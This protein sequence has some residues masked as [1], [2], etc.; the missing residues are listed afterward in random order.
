MNIEIYL[1]KVKD[2]FTYELLKA[3][4]NWSGYEYVFGV[5]YLIAIVFSLLMFARRNI[6]KGYFI[7]FSSTAILMFLFLPVLAPK[8]EGYTQDAPIEFYKSLK[9]KECYVRVLGFKS[10]ADLFY[11]QKPMHLS[12]QYIK[13]EYSASFE[14]WL[15]KGNIDKPA[16]FVCKNTSAKKYLSNPG[17]LPLYQKN[18]FVF[19]KREAVR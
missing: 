14:E 6:L 19:M 10:Y 16:Y 11:S 15:L 5:L 8:I 12:E 4:V 1:P 2:P 7:I 3:N 13:K 9:G 17:M 18:G